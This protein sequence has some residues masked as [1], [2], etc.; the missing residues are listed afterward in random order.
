MKLIIYIVILLIALWIPVR[1]TDISNLEPV[2]AIWIDKN[3][4]GYVVKTDTQDVGVG[5][6]LQKALEEMKEHC[7]KLIYMDTTQYLMVSE[8]CKEAIAEISQHLKNKVRVCVWNGVGE[9]KNAVQYVK[10]HRNGV[11]IK[12]YVPGIQLPTIPDLQKE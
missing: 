7:D 5:E 6:T 10:S 8:D 3:E 1:K 9:L 11:A 2:Q 12:D 4:N